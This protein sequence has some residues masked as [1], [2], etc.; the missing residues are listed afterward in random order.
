MNGVRKFVKEGF[1][2][3]LSGVALTACLTL[4]MLAAY[5]GITMFKNIYMENKDTTD[6]AYSS[7]TLFVCYAEDV[8]ELPVLP[9]GIPCNL[10]MLN[11]NVIT[12]NENTT[13]L[14]DIIINSYDE[15]YPL[16]S[17]HYANETE[18]GQGEYVIVL[19]QER[20]K[21][22]YLVGDEFYYKIFGEEYRVIGVT[23]TE[24]SVVFDYSLF[25][26]L[27]CIGEN[28][29]SRLFENS[30]SA[31]GAFY[32]ALESNTV[33]TDAIFQ[34]YIEEQY[35]A[36]K[37]NNQLQSTITAAPIN[38][39]KGFCIIIYLFCFFCIGIVIR[40]W[41]K[42]RKHE[43]QICRAFGYTNGRIVL[44]LLS[45]FGRIFL[46][47]LGIFAVCCVGIHLLMRQV[48]M[49]YRLEFSWYTVLPYVGIFLL[50]IPIVSG[51]SL[52][53]F[54]HNSVAENL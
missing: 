9:E 8:S 18:L 27:D 42:Q 43:M 22:A 40:F 23:G 35:S 19:G 21:D 47:S 25:L 34:E 12:D 11:C 29:L 31:Q 17:G 5:Y 24:D 46:V 14:A 54:L 37:E 49:E 7:R 16:V 4:S 52:Y 28:T 32:F 10:K 33:D 53:D 44:R 36:A 1:R 6:Y 26:Y 45:S 48:V 30:V 13:C 15:N 50:S 39:E 20:L 41:L 38:N 51:K 3:K 2:Y